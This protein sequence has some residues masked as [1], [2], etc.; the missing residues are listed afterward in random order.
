M[1][2][3]PYSEAQFRA[4]VDGALNR[5]KTL[6][7]NTRSPQYPADLA[8][9]YDEK[10]LLSD[11]MTNSAI[12]GLFFVLESLGLTKDQLSQMKEW[13]QTRSVSLRLKVDLKCTFAPKVERE[14]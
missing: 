4:R 5:V 13:A 7:E 14:V 11:S 9:K 6:L 8:H 1:A 12:A 3:V 2:L 10:Y